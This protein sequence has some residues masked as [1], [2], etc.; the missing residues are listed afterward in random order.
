MKA[1]G[2]AAVAPAATTSVASN[3]ANSIL[4]SADP[5]DPIDLGTGPSLTNE[6]L[7]ERLG[8]LARKNDRMDLRQLGTSAG[9]NDPIWEAKLGDGDTNIHVINQIHGDE[10]FGTEALLSIFRRLVDGE[11]RLVD[12]ILDNLSIT[13][14]P[15][16]N[17]DG[18]MYTEDE[19][20]DG[21]EQRLGNRQNSQPWRSTHS[22]QRPYYHVEEF[23]GDERGG[24]DP[25]RD[26]NIQPDFI[27]KV[28]DT[29]DMWQTDDDGEPTG[30]LDMERDGHTLGGSG[31]QATPQVEAIT[32]SFLEADPD[33]AKTIHSQGLP[34]DPETGEVTILSIM[35]PYGPMYAEEAPFGDPEEDE[36]ASFVN[37]FLDQETSDRGI[38]LNELCAQAL[39]EYAGPWSV[40]ETGT[41]FGY[42]TLWGSYLDA[43]CPQTDA[44]GMLYEL[45]GQSDFIGD[46]GYY[47][48]VEA[49]RVALLESFSEL[50][51]DPSLSQAGIEVDDYF[52]R[53]L[54]EGSYEEGR[55]Q[56]PLQY[57]R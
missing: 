48:K 24:Y 27:S 4:Q 25:N 18:A 14:I 46:R 52:D 29:P 32:Q 57:Q 35:A 41:R 49:T 28:D 39:E 31:V 43:L 12:N 50:A 40:F 11:S 23:P 5:L 13:V 17:P 6:Q 10:P 45:P 34:L 47:L 56:S 7:T 53:P 1:A 54:A 2:L 33:Y 9:R 55:G 16:A 3:P 21:E 20:G 37:P 15:R 51:E 38:R 19:N 42:T 44:A 30:V 26:F 36:T 22:H 8:L